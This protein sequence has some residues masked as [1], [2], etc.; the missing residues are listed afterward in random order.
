MKKATINLICNQ[1]IG[2]C[3]KTTTVAK[4]FKDQYPELDIEVSMSHP[5]VYFNNPNVVN[6]GK[7]VPKVINAADEVEVKKLNVVCNQD[8]DNGKLDNKFTIHKLKENQASFLQG[9]IGY[10]NAK[11][12]FNLKITQ[13]EPDIYLTKEEKLPFEDLPKKFWVV[14]AGCE[15][16]NQRKN[17][18]RKYWEDIFTALPD[19]TFIQNGLTKDMHSPFPNHKNVINGL[20]KYNVRE[21]MRLIY[22]SQ[23]VISPISWNMHCA[24][25]FK[26]PCIALAGGGEDVSW[27]NY[28]YYGFNYLHTIGSFDCCQSGGCWKD[29]CIN[30]EEDGTQKCMQI[31][32]PDIIINLVKKYGGDNRKSNR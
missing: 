15:A 32:T 10:I 20:D 14:N 1:Q 11:Y 17:Y 2:D 16:K 13:E 30:K 19:V 22:H 8:D 28:K 12:N 26:K 18:P 4:L 6:N 25:A 9:M 29:T 3:I 24:A 21:T 5:S 7:N 27:E 31:I 23:G